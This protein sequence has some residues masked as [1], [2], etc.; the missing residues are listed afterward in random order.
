MPANLPYYPLYVNDFEGSERVRMMNLSEIG[1]Y[2][3]CLN[4]QWNVGSIPSDIGDLSKA[5]KWDRREVAKCWP[6]VSKCFVPIASDPTRLI[7][8]RQHKERQKALTKSE[9]ASQ[10]VRTRYE[11]NGTVPVCIGTNEPPHASESVSVSVSNSS[12]TENFSKTSNCVPPLPL[13]PTPDEPAFWSEH[14]YEKHPK[15]KDKALVFSVVLRLFERLGQNAREYFEKT[16]SPI[17]D[18]WIA[19]AEWQRASGRYV[20]SLAKWLDDDGFT[21]RPEAKS[22]WD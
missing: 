22:A 8:E 7:N 17:H 12:N 5:I 10:A 4:R 14:L 2:I 13:D 19:S 18:E 11:R 16:I 3:L 21:R 20:P 9:R 15:K 6:A 1:L